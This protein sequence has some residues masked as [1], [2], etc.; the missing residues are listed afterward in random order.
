MMMMIICKY[1]T[2]NPLG[3][4]GALAAQ[5][6]RSFS[7]GARSP[8][9]NQVTS[10]AVDRVSTKSYM[11]RF[12]SS[13]RKQVDALIAIR[14]GTGILDL[15]RSIGLDNNEMFQTWSTLQEHRDLTKLGRMVTCDSSGRVK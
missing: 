11:E 2:K 13:E 8:S 1:K 12:E 7:L 3:W 14:D 5:F 10:P 6:L 9:E 15:M 4:V